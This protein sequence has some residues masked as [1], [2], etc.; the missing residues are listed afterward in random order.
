MS[1]GVKP[2]AINQSINFLREKGAKSAAELQ[3]NQAE[4]QVED[5]KQKIVH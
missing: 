1:K 4:Q 2:A 3:I 5:N